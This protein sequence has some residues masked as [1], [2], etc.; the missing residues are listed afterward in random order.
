[1]TDYTIRESMK[2]VDAFFRDRKVGTIAMITM[3]G[4]LAAHEN[5]AIKNWMGSIDLAIPADA[6]ILR[7]GDIAFHNR[8]RDVENNTFVTEF[9]KKIVRQKKNVY[10]LSDNQAELNKLKNDILSYEEDVWIVG[11]FCL[12]STENDGDYVVNEINMTFAD[13]L[14][15]NLGTPQREC[16][17]ADN[18][19]KL[20]VAIWMMVRPDVD[21]AD[22]EK[23]FF[24][25]LH[26]RMVKKIFSAKLL[27]YHKN[28]SK[29]TDEAD[30]QKTN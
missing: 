13:V 7:A 25:A 26:K 28:S 30:T 9:F 3:R 18:H 12:D 23:G 29:Q 6:E 14:I 20:N 22:K 27:H 11:S 15:S 2:K 8:V 24:V 5:E 10:L 1:M 16:F 4:L 21:L 17:F 19:M